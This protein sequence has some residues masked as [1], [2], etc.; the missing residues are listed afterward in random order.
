M[1]EEEEEKEE[2]EKE[3]EK[4]SMSLAGLFSRERWLSR[5]TPNSNRRLTSIPVYPYIII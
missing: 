3:E 2:E 5:L 1:R 4:K